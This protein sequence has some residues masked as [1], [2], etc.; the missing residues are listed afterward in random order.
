MTISDPYR[1]LEDAAAAE[2]EAW[3]V[4]QDALFE[5]ERGGWTGLGRLRE[6]IAD[7]SATGAITAP[8][9]RGK[10][11]F[12]M[13]R[14]PEQE[15]LVLLTVDEAGE[16]KVLIDPIALNPNGTTTLDG[17][18]PSPSGRLLAYQISEGG[19]EESVL[20]VMN[21]ATGEVVDGPIDRTRY[22]EVAWLNDE[23]G[24]YYTRRLAPELVPPDQTQYHRRIYLHRLGTDPNEDV[25]IFGDGARMTDYHDVSISADGRWLQIAT[26]EGTDTRNDV[27]LADLAGADPA[28]PPLKP[29][30]L[31]VDAQS[32]LLPARADSPLAGTALV[33]TTLEA[34][35]GRV[36]AVSTDDPTPDAWREIVSED[37]EV[38]IENLVVL[39]G[40]EL[41]R[42]LLL[43]ARTRH[44]I[45]EIVVHDA[46]TGEIYE[47][48]PLPHL[49]TVSGL[50]ARRDGGY[51]AWFN[52]ADYGSRSRVFRYDG[53][54][55]Q[56]FVWSDTPGKPE[57]PQV[58]TRQV[59]YTSKDG[60]TVRMFI[61]SGEPD[62]VPERPR[63][64]ILYGYG[65]FNISLRPEYDPRIAGLGRGRRRIRGRQSARRRRRGR[66][67][68]PGRD[69]RQQAERLRRLPRRRAST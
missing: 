30:H 35:R 11:S 37:P 9:W 28:A 60:T 68:A 32:F 69:L 18:S 50:T 16:E 59:E 49:G 53:R 41:D 15:H 4:A 14:L 1:W 39:D 24:Y 43:V 34:P 25:L 65:G 54:T 45:S 8:V 29:V 2:T 67:L 47:T 46:V 64:T 6:R 52:S 63:P 23:S 44:A 40:P 61:V 38:V 27:Y 48:V 5:Q 51:E 36:C 22:T 55:G 7:L 57:T 10:R 42:P 13:R 19:T 62:E 58:Y 12:L 26:Y 3:S 20:R 56:T 33:L 66:G 21:V 17:W 31:G